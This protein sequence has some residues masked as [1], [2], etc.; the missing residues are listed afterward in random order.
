MDSDFEYWLSPNCNYK[1]VE[2]VN[3]R[4]DEHK[5]VFVGLRWNYLE[6]KHSCQLGFGLTWPV[7]SNSKLGPS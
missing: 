4:N 5:Y 7:S 2:R 6:N 1:V 3:V